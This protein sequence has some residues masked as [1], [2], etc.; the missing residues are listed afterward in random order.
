MKIDIEGKFYNNL[1]FLSNLFIL[2]FCFIITSIFIIT[3][4]DSLA[5]SYHVIFLMKEN[6]VNN[7][8]KQ[9][10]KAFKLNFKQSLPL[11]IGHLFLLFTSIYFIMMFYGGETR[12]DKIYF[13]LMVIFFL[14]IFYHMV[15][16]YALLGRYENNTKNIIINAFKIGIINYKANIIIFLFLFTVYSLF[17]FNTI[18]IIFGASI[19]ITIGFSLVRYVVSTYLLKVFKKYES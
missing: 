13:S 7:V 8:F 3:I 12:T 1:M 2:N 11:F 14:F 10:F 17:L 9:Y 5:S 19:F 16:T 15:Y 4:G 18:T 6:K